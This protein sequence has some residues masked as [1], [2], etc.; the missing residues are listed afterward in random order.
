MRRIR[1]CLVESVAI[2]G[3]C[4]PLEAIF[5]LIEVTAD[6]DRDFSFS[7]EHWK[8]GVQ[9]VERGREF[10]S[11]IYYEQN[12]GQTTDKMV[13][14]KDFSELCILFSTP[15]FYLLLW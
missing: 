15:L 11:K 8:S 1:E 9:N 6:E 4:K 12:R 14:H 13:Q 2:M 10:F 3:V 5:A 7:R